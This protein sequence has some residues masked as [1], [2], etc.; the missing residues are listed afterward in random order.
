MFN[1]QILER[2]YLIFIR[3]R[4]IPCTNFDMAKKELTGTKLNHTLSVLRKFNTQKVNANPDLN[5]YNNETK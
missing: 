2:R 5:N 1:K 4:N 3:I